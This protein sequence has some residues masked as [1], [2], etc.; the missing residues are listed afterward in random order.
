VAGDVEAPGPAE[1]VGDHCVEVRRGRLLG[2]HRGVS[3]G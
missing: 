3:S 1:A 2:D